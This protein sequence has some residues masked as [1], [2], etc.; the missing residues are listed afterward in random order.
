MNTYLVTWVEP[1]VM[2]VTIEADSEEGAINKFYQHEYDSMTAETI[3]S[4]GVVE[5][6]LEAEKIV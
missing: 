2:T 5:G 4:L 1:L 6:S 3:D